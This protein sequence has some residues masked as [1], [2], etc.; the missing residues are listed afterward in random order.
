[1]DKASIG[2][3]IKEKRLALDLSRRILGNAIGVTPQAI[4]RYELGLVDIPSS[5]LMALAEALH[6]SSSEL[7]GEETPS[8]A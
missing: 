4:E 1:M 3:R 8:H 5:R 2:K 7:L 6:I